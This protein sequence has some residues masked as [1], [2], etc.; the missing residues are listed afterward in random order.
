MQPHSSKLLLS[1]PDIDVMIPTAQD[2]TALHYAVRQWSNFPA[3]LTVLE[4]LLRCG[5]QL[6][7]QNELGETALHHGSGSLTIAAMKGSQ[8]SVAWLLGHGASPD[9]MSRKRRSDPVANQDITPIFYAIQSGNKAI[10]AE[11]LKGGADP[12]W[13][14]KSLACSARQLAKQQWPTQYRELFPEGLQRVVTSTA[15]NE[16]RMLDADRA[17]GNKKAQQVDFPMC[18]VGDKVIAQSRLYTGYAYARWIG[19]LPQRP[20]ITYVGLECPHSV[21]NGCDGSLSGKRSG[22]G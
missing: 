5:A 1:L 12:D 11:F 22:L 15:L 20:T 7:Y 4:G 18:K 9:V 21:D 3:Q 16:E 19:T 17:K 2:T 14:S 8:A 10:V 6:D 13:Q